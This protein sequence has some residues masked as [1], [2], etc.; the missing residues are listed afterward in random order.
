MV[1]ANEM[2]NVFS[3]ILVYWVR[4][5]A[6]IVK[7]NCIQNICMQP[8]VLVKCWFGIHTSRWI[9]RQ[10]WGNVEPNM[11]YKHTYIWIYKHTWIYMYEQIY[12]YFINDIG[13]HK[14]VLYG[15]SFINI[16]H[17]S[18]CTASI[19]RNWKLFNRQSKHSQF[20]YCVIYDHLVIKYA[21]AIPLSFATEAL[22]CSCHDCTVLF[23]WLS[24]HT[25]V[26]NALHGR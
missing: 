23:R 10:Y 2:N 16:I 26:M 15:S 25:S 7:Q 9:P 4:L 14:Q 20:C 22:R 11:I 19:H 1:C 24:D 6:D 5:Y 12:I 13:N 3:D 17:M 18:H 21:P 8:C